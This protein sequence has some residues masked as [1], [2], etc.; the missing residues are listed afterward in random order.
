MSDFTG[1]STEALDFYDDLEMDNTRSFWTAHKSVYDQQVRAP[2]EAMLALLEKEFGAA[3]I[4]RPYRDVRFAKDKTPYKTNQGAFVAT[5][6]ATGWYVDLSA[7]GVRVGAGFYHAESE[8]LGRF[9]RAVDDDLHGSELE[10]LL[11]RLRRTKW[12]ISGDRL[13]TSP[14][15]FDADHPRI[16]LLRHRSLTISKMYGFEP[17]IHS[18]DL[19][20]QVRRDWRKARPLVEWITTNATG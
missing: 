12:D 13:K 18:A 4:F 9:R 19:V 7:A 1:F 2:M 11:A 20:G 15:G 3:K 14:R 17:I 5:A 8:L 16:D 6:P 10:G